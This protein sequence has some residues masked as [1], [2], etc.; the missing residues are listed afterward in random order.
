M[1]ACARAGAD[2]VDAASDAMSGTT[3]QPAIGA[4]VASTAGT[5]Y[6]TGLDLKEI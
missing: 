4:I 2:A 5:E 6:D 1:L 3:S